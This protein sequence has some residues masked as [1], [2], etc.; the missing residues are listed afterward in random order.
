MPRH[1]GQSDRSRAQCPAREQRHRQQ[2]AEA[3]QVGLPS[4]PSR[5]ILGYNGAVYQRPADT[6][7]W[8]VLYLD[9]R[10]H[11]WM[12]VE[13]RRILNHQP[14]PTHPLVAHRELR[15]CLDRHRRPRGQRKPLAV[16]GDPVPHRRVRPRRPT[17]RRRHPAGA[18]RPRPGRTAM[19]GQPSAS[20]TGRRRA[21]ERHPAAARNRRRSSA[22]SGHASARPRE[23][24]HL[25][26]APA[27]LAGDARTTSPLPS[28]AILP[29]R[30]SATSNTSP[31]PTAA[32][33]AP[34]PV[35]ASKSRR[36][37][38]WLELSTRAPSW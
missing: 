36:V 3:L 10:P 16:G 31:C 13:L 30:L 28:V 38:S 11:R 22:L 12:I 6:V 37:P 24:A 21:T 5:V 17:S 7:K 4:A 9:P 14:R 33:P 32:P 2:A 15:I 34:S 18:R 1:I 8:Q 20:A 27:D 26:E 19:S 35:R 25:F 23:R 29:S